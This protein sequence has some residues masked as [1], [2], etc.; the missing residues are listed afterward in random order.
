MSTARLPITIVT[1]FLGSGKTTLLRYLLAKSKQRLAVMV[2]EFGTVGL[3]GEP[4]SY[5]PHFI[6]FILLWQLYVFI[7]KRRKK[8]KADPLT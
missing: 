8:S 5:F 4:K 7:L 3:D 2:N 1:G 6:T